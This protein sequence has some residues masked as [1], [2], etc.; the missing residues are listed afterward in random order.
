MAKMSICGPWKKI[1]KIDRS[2]SVLGINLNGFF[3]RE[4]GSG[5]ITRF[6]LDK[7][8]CRF[9]L[10]VV[11]PD[12]YKLEVKKGCRVSERVVRNGL[13]KDDGWRWFGDSSGTF[14]VQNLRRKI[15]DHLYGDGSPICT[16]ESWIPIKINCFVWR[17]M[18]NR[19]PVAVNLIGVECPRAKEVWKEISIWCCWDL[20]GLD[21]L[22]YLLEMVNEP[23]EKVGR[24]ILGS[25]ISSS[26]WFIWKQRNGR[27]FN[28][29]SLSTQFI[30]DEI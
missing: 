10:K 23:D 28:K 14:S 16:W 4:V 22:E 11:F 3:I 25:I 26:L 18:Q 21:S 17:L 7:W 15:A 5:N 8:L 24:R 2:F 6:W 19:I 20:T 27:R 1:S 9:P 12:L 29:G 30:V 13:G